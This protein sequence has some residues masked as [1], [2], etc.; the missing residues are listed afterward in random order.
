M[1]KFGYLTTQNVHTN[2]IETT[3]VFRVQLGRTSSNFSGTLTPSILSSPRMAR[4]QTGPTMLGLEDK[5][6]PTSSHTNI[7]ETPAL[8]D[9]LYLVSCCCKDGCQKNCECVKSSLKCSSMCSYCAGHGCSNKD[10]ED[11]LDVDKE[12]ENFNE[13]E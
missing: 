10:V 9:I 5:K 6:R 13:N 11:E 3:Y 2:Y 4:E 8:E 12:T 1:Q 7:E